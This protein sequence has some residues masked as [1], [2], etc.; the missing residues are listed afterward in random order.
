MAAPSTIYSTA[1]AKCTVKNELSRKETGYLKRENLLAALSD[2]F[3]EVENVND[4]NAKVSAASAHWERL[5][6]TRCRQ[7]IRGG[8]FGRQKQSLG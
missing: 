3:P 5:K 4:F 8:F 2:Q 7:S 6:M 1:P